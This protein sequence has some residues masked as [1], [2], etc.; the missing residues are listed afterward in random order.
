MQIDCL[1]T[2]LK[3]YFLEA[4]S[5]VALARRLLSELLPAQSDPWVLKTSDG[6]DVIAYFNVYSKD[7]DEMEGP[8]VIYADISGRHYNEDKVVVSVLTALQTKL[9]GTILDDR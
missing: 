3:S 2:P 4:V 6:A 8:Y 9:A 1:E 5:D 7:D